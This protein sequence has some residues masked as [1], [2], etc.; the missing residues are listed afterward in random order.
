MLESITIS[1]F[2][3][4]KAVLAGLIRGRVP[5]IQFVPRHRI[6]P[7]RMLQVQ[8][9]WKGIESTLADLI[10]RF[11]LETNCCLEFG[12]EHGYSTVALSSFFN[13][14]VGVD[15]FV[16][17]EHTQDYRDIYLETVNR[18]AVF[19]NIRLVRSDFKDWIKQDHNSYDLIHVDIVHTYSDTFACGLW[20]ALH[21]RCAI[22]HD[23]ETF[24]AVKRAVSEI[25]RRTGKT[26][27]NLRESCGLGILV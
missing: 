17:D 14:V 16:G 12:V 9:A 2:E 26:F 5:S 20:S 8:S 18:L 10:D 21:S 19:E 25:S 11:Q 6:L 15:T 7:S 23:T 3:Y 13:S 22:F 27:Y 24:P 4:W 1:E